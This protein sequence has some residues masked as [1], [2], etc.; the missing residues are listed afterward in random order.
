MARKVVSRK[1]LR[2]E[3]EAAERSGS[4]EKKPED[5]KAAKPKAAKRKSR[6][7]EAKVVRVRLFWHVVNQSMKP[8]AKFEYHQKAA[9][10]KKAEDLSQGGKTPH[11]LHKHREEIADT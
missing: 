6:V 7:A 4:E 5:K 3:V 2:E 11:F 9:A 8:V 1:A 10:Q